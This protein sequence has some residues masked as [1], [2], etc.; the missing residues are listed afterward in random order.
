MVLPDISH[1][2][3]F[4]LDIFLGFSHIKNV[5][6]LIRTATYGHSLRSFHKS[7]AH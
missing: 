6:G 7:R 2:L 1:C 4:T 5:K 3:N